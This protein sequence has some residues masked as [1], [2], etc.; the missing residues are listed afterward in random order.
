[1]TYNDRYVLRTEINAQTG[2]TVFTLHDD[3]VH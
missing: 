2:L 1:M 3:N